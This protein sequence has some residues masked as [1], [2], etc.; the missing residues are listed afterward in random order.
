MNVCLVAAA[1]LQ[2]VK[3]WLQP[4]ACPRGGALTQARVVVLTLPNAVTI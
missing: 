4:V 1:H 3:F 2:V